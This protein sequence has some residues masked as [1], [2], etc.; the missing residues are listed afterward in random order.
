M[1]RW[2]FLLALPYLVNVSTIEPPMGCGGMQVVDRYGKPH[3]GCE[4][5]PYNIYSVGGIQCEKNSCLDLAQ[6]L[7]FAHQLRI[8]PRLLDPFK[9]K[10]PCVWTGTW[11]DCNPRG[12]KAQ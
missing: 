5:Y 6:A 4:G 1:K 9:C 3:S 10:D 12:E 2:L 7:N 8:T 11:C